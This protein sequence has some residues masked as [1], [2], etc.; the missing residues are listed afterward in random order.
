[1]WSWK[2]LE[3]FCLP[4]PQDTPSENVTYGYLPPPQRDS[5]T[6]FLISRSYLY[7]FRSNP[8]PILKVK[9]IEFVFGS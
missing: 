3:S 2:V 8:S 4:I 1:M 7:P 5:T 9:A 6:N